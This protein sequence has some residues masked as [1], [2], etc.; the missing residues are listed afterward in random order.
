MNCAKT[1]LGTSLRLIR[2]LRLKGAPKARVL[3]LAMIVLSKS[4]KAARTVLSR[5][6]EL[7]TIRQHMV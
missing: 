3:D 4:K 5:S 7:S 1:L 2:P 6:T